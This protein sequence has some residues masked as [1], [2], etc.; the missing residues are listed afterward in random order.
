MKPFDINDFNVYRTDKTIELLSDLDSKAIL[1]N[2]SAFANSSGGVILIGIKEECHTTQPTNIIE[3]E[4]TT[5][6]LTD[7]TKEDYATLQPTN[8]NNEEQTFFQPTGLKLEEREQITQFLI[9]LFKDKNLVNINILTKENIIEYSLDN[10]L[11]IAVFV[12][13]ANIEQRPIHL[14]NNEYRYTIMRKNGTNYACSFMQVEAMLRDSSNITSDMQTTYDST[15]KEL[16]IQTIERFR[17]R[18]S[19]LKKGNPL[20]SLNTID[21]LYQI[22]AVNHSKVDKILRPT[23]AG[24]LMFGGEEA[25]LRYFPFF[26]LE[27]KEI[28]ENGVYQMKICSNDGDNF[29][30]IFDFY[31][32]VYNRLVIELNYS[33]LHKVLGELLLNCLINADY[34]E[35]DT[36]IIKKNKNSITFENSGCL[37]VSKEQLYKGGRSTSRNKSIA[38]MFNQLTLGHSCGTG[39]PYILRFCEEYNYNKIMVNETLDP[40]RTTVDF[41]INIEHADT[42]ISQN[43]IPTAKLSSHPKRHKKT[44]EQID[45]IEFYIK[46]YGKVTVPQLSNL[47]Q[48]STSRVRKI[49]SQMDNVVVID[50]TY[51]NRVYTIRKTKKNIKPHSYY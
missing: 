9:N 44:Q 29:L 28:D 8:T 39:I 31:L 2:Y 12:P 37:R 49:L 15:L 34:Y 17:K 46:K 3:E 36:V 24:M 26:S 20:F 42:P 1:F 19:L 6:Q 10:H 16:N 41:E 38:K 22:G 40:D 45:C 25:I 4:Q 51:R 43:T 32:Q 23:I 21:Y 48:L 7:T 33:S 14:Y 47:L 50:K 11:V 5:F 18:H 35:K 27:Y 13:R 30:N